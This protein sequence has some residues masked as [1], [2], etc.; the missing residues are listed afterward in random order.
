ML[1]REMIHLSREG[2]DIREALGTDS[3][4][5]A[6]G[7]AQAAGIRP[8]DL[9]GMLMGRGLVPEPRRG[10]ENYD[11]NAFKELQKHLARREEPEPEIKLTRR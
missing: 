3:I 7:I 9:P 6:M 2:M 8:E 4:E 1:T 10:E 11:E 5:E